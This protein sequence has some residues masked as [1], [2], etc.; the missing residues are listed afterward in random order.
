MVLAML[1]SHSLSRRHFLLST[2]LAASSALLGLPGA[3]GAEETQTE[4][5]VGCRD[6]YLNLAGKSDTWSCMKTLGADCTEVLV[7]LDLKTP[8]LFHPT[9]QYSLTTENGLRAIKEDA[10]ENGCRISAFMRGTRFDERLEQELESARRLVKVAEQL[11]VPAIRIDVWPRAIP[12]DKFLPFAIKTCKQ[13]CEIAQDTPVRFGVENHGHT[14]N[15][16]AFLDKLFDGVDSPHLGL[17]MDLANF[18]WYGDPL[19]KLYAIY[20]KYA[21]R[22]VHTH[23]KSIHY[24]ADKRNI[25]REMGW[26]YGKDCCP[27]YEGDIDY[28]RVIRIFRENGFHGDLCI[29]DESLGH[30]PQTERARVIRREIAMLR[31][32]ARK[33]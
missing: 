31:S 15:N 23:C 29:E 11:G 4:W 3:L 12:E 28:H 25:Q 9:R 27:I 13:L 17:T 10:A 21:S 16:T 24:P 14:T 1:N 22:A 20:A 2:S 19:D 18:Y 8:G 26:E 6:I 32:L 5:P 30:F 7:S 33:A